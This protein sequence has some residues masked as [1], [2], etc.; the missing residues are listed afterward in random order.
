[1]TISRA[2]L[3]K[4]IL[5]AI[6]VCGDDGCCVIG[7]DANTDADGHH[8]FIPLWGPPQRVAAMV[9]NEVERLLRDAGHGDIVVYRKGSSY[10]R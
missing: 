10:G 8:Y 9:A 5:K 3:E 1:M 2:A 6:P 4:A 7:T